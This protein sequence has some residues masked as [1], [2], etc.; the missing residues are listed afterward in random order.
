MTRNIAEAARDTAKSFYD[1]AQKGEFDEK[2]AKELARSAIRS[3]RYDNGNYVF[4]YDYQGENLATAPAPEREGKNFLDALD[5][6]G[7]KFIKAMIEVAQKGG[8]EVFYYFPKPGEQKP[9]RKLSSATGF[10]PWHWM[11]GTGVYLDDLEASFWRSVL[12]LSL[13]SLAGLGVLGAVAYATMQAIAPP[14]RA[15]AGITSNIGKGIYNTPI[16]ATDRSDEIGILARAMVEFTESAREAERLQDE[17]DRQ[18]AAR[19]QR[20]LKLESL[21][22]DFDGAISSVIAAMT[23]ASQGLTVTAQSMAS[24]AEQTHRQ[25]DAVSLSSNR[26]AENVQTVAAAAEELTA[27]IQEIS[28]QVGDAARISVAA[29]EE[30][31]RTNAKVQSLAASAERIGE[32]VSLINDI[33]SQTNL[34]ALNATIEAARAGEAGKGFA[35]VAGEVKHLAS[36]TARATEDINKQ[37]STVQEET[38]EA[39]TAIRHIGAVIDEIRQISTTIAAAVEQQGVATRGIAENVQHA[40][41]GTQEVSSNIRGVSEA[42]ESTGQAATGVMHS[43]TD[44]AHRSEKLQV[45]VVKYLESVR[46]L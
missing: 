25:A 17:Q 34:L 18:Q 36:Q 12:H 41:V 2:T 20:A 15:L 46:S 24:T 19:E 3:M 16:P 42:A 32:V 39:V 31:N 21:S 22:R 30:T 28:R 9:T 29:S 37:I 44:M 33:A 14:I 43:A 45:E 11:I 13:I 26:A 23:D 40:A 8:G 4:I 5:T 38:R 1:R 7:L 10:D 6:N 35:V 27:S